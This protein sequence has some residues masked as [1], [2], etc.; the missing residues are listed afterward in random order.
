L[1]AATIASQDL[2]M[3]KTNAIVNN[4]RHIF[5][6]SML[7]KDF[8]ICRTEATAIIKHVLNVCVGEELLKDLQKHK[9]SLLVDET[10]CNDNKS[11]I[12]VWVRYYDKIKVQSSLFKLLE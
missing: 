4:F 10:T 6:D 12:A 1:L 11:V 7:A 9:F 5:R 2:A 3:N 8:K